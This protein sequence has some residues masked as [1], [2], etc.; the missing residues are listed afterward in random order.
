MSH[1]DDTYWSFPGGPDAPSG[2]TH[3][4]TWDQDSLTHAEYIGMPLYLRLRD[5][6]QST[7]VPTVAHN[8]LMLCLIDS[9]D[10]QVLD[11]GVACVTLITTTAG[12]GSLQRMDIVDHLTIEPGFINIL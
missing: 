12:T 9:Y 6:L 11:T 5:R 7:R 1:E 8:L 10:S 3:E 2:H 4:W